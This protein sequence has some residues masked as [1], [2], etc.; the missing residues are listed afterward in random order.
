MPRSAP[1]TARSP[2]GAWPGVRRAGQRRRAR[3]RPPPLP[4][5]GGTA[6][7]PAVVGAR[8]LPPRRH[9]V[10]A[11]LPPGV[12]HHAAN[13]VSDS[14][15]SASAAPAA[16]P[17]PQTQTASASSRTTCAPPPRPSATPGWLGSAPR[18][19]G[20][21][22]GSDPALA[23]SRQP[24]AGQLSSTDTRRVTPAC[25]PVG[26]TVTP[27]ASRALDGIERT[28]S[29]APGPAWRHGAGPVAASIVV[30]RSRSTCHTGT[31]SRARSIVV[32]PTTRPVP[33]MR[34]VGVDARDLGRHDESSDHSAPL[35]Q[36]TELGER[37][38]PDAVPADPAA[39]LD[40]ASTARRRRPPDQ[41]STDT[42]VSPPDVPRSAPPQRCG[43]R[44][45]PGPP[46]PPPASWSSRRRSS[47]WR[48]AASRGRYRGRPQ[49]HRR[50]R[51]VVAGS[52]VAG[53]SADR[54]V[55][56]VRRDRA[57]TGGRSPSPVTAGRVASIPAP[58]RLVGRRAD[59]AQRQQGG[60]DAGERA[61]QPI[62][63]A[64]GG[65][66]GARSYRALMRRC[67][68]YGRYDRRTWQAPDGQNGPGR[69]G[70]N[71]DSSCSTLPSTPSATSGPARRWS[72]SPPRAG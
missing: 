19:C 55:R 13:P 62:G 72:R 53:H 68:P 8:L 10:A 34:E 25:G 54:S 1:P 49:R 46:A 42:C 23:A 28:G 45:A 30:V 66:R 17:I 7:H 59:A 56:I 5:S 22:A 29:P 35:A 2:L 47:S 36:R 38:S 24:A 67:R 51:D 18:P 65:H 57:G 71:G 39:A 15:T 60:D 26:V 64:D 70:R 41:S 4:R 31:A 20:R 16:G 37:R 27:S 6:R 63:E 3:R 9:E 52:L 50:R 32:S 33:A 58:R 14:A 61:A 43:P 69:A 44:T 12:R 40:A 11:R 21:P 48:T